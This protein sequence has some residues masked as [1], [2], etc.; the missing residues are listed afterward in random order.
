[1]KLARRLLN[2]WAARL[3]R[4]LIRVQLLPEDTD[5][6]LLGLRVLGLD[7]FREGQLPVMLAALRR[8]S[9]LAVMPTGSGKSACFQVPTLLQPG[10]SYVI[11]PLKALMHDQVS[12]LQFR[13]ISATF[14]NS[15]L[16]REEKSLRYVLLERGTLKFLYLAPER[17]D[18]GEV[19][20]PTEVE[21]LLDHRPDFLVVDEAH[22]VDRW[23]DDF[24]PSY[25]RLAEVRRALG[26]PS[27][28]AF[29]ATAGKE[30]QQRILASLGASDA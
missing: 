5:R 4:W 10:T 7:Q 27:L 21:R 23:G 30:A 11:S 28:L 17:L 3:A 29:T 6:L 13:Q 22:Y 19:R 20:D 16:D 14:I 15:D 24:R 26:N 25:G 18:P 12:G 1:V 2:W 8:E 9:L